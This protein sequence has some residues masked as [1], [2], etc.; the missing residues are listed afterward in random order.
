MPDPASWLVV[1]PGWTVL[2]A[3]G[4]EVGTVEQTL[5]DPERDIFDGFAIS[6]GRLSKPRYVPAEKVGVIREGEVSLDLSPSEVEDLSEY[7]P[8]RQG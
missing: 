3:D 2:A 5:G 4:S 1:E 8:P 7:Q 6:T